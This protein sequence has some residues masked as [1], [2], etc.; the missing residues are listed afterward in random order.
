[1][2][3]MYHN[4]AARSGFNTVST[5]NFTQ[6]LRCLQEHGYRCIDL[7][8]YVALVRSG[9]P[10]HKTVAITFDDAYTSFQ[11][12]ALPILTQFEFPA[13]VFVPTQ[14]V[15]Q[16]NVWDDGQLSIMDWA[17]IRAV[18]SSPWVT[19]GSHGVGHQHMRAL[20]TEAIT[21]ELVESKQ[22]LEQA[23]GLPVQHFS[24]P[25]GQMRD[26]DRR[27]QQAA[28]AAGY[29]SACSTIWGHSQSAQQLYALHRLEI[30]PQDDLPMFFAKISRP[31][32][33]K[34]FRQRAKNLLYRL[35]I[36]R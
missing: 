23:L 26:F 4:I 10:L 14:F 32:H 30:E 6:Q 20:T 17:G 31:F 13:T 15:G 1:M 5:D 21:A 18:A 2:I 25:F 33:P 19:V 16:S 7:G 8:S 34:Y 9:Q 24:F 27:C 28:A 35:H 22:I 11:D 12:I 36:R 29:L 3:L